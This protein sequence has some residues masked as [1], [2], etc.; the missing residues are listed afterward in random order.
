[1]APVNRINPDIV[2]S[3]LADGPDAASVV[4]IAEHQEGE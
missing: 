2:E 4:R 3:I 1:V